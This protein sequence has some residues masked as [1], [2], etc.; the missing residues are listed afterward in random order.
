MWGLEFSFPDECCVAF[1]FKA[2]SDNEH[3]V[4]NNCIGGVL[5]FSA[6]WRVLML[7]WLILT[8]F[9]FS[10]SV[11]ETHQLAEAQ[12]EKNVKLRQAFGISEYFIE[13]SS[14]D[15]NRKVR[16]SA[17]RMAAET[18]TTSTT[19][20]TSYAIVRTPSPPAGGA[21]GAATRA[22]PPPGSRSNRPK[23]PKRRKTRTRRRKSQR[24]RRRRSERKK[25]AAAIRRTRNQTRMNRPRRRRNKRR[26]RR[27]RVAVT[28]RIPT[29]RTTR[30]TPSRKRQQPSS[31]TLVANGAPAATT[32]QPLQKRSAG[33]TKSVATTDVETIDSATTDGATTGTATIDAATTGTVTTGGATTATTTTGNASVAIGTSATKSGVG[34]RSKRPKRLLAWSNSKK[35]RRPPRQRRPSDAARR[36]PKRPGASRNSKRPKSVACASSC[37]WKRSA[38]VKPRRSSVAPKRPLKRASRSRRRPKVAAVTIRRP[39]T[40]RNLHRTHPNQILPLHRK[41]PTR[42]HRRIPTHRRLRPRRQRR[43]RR[44]THLRHHRRAPRVSAR[45]RSLDAPGRPASSTGDVSPGTK[46][47]PSAK[48]KEIISSSKEEHATRNA[49]GRFFNYSWFSLTLLIFVSL[50]QFSFSTQY[51]WFSYLLKRLWCVHFLFI[52]SSVFFTQ[53]TGLW[54]FFGSAF[55]WL[56]VNVCR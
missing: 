20:T 46:T 48:W 35:P 5:S 37:C 32:N 7:T 10:G 52:F 11:K 3:L 23:R 45:R 24:T 54:I 41:I 56:V 8:G 15:P 43:R 18:T 17:A 21:G 9:I 2:N 29:N 55:Y 27:R 51:I 33:P 16:E 22:P 47:L 49:I 40:A 53:S 31:P 38:S 30:K 14:L 44:R 42:L 28:T 12:Q 1:R 6:V 26:R 50:C 19:T 13:G 34:A 25:A 4:K 36:R 39:V